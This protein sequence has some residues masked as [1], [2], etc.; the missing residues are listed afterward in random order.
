[1]LTS[2]QTALA[3][4][5]SRSADMQATRILQNRLA[6]LTRRELEV[7]RHVITGKLNKQIASDLG[8]GEQNIKVHRM[9]MM[10]KM[11]V[12]SV[13]ELVRVST[14]LGIEMAAD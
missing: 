3:L 4:A 14:R 6:L 12:E 13:A 5:A 8:T 11:G 2:V 1:L 10:D 7:M 9:R